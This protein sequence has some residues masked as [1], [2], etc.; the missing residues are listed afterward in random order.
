M[1]IK[2]ALNLTLIS[3]LILSIPSPTCAR[4]C[5]KGK[6]CGKGCIAL[7]K[8][9]RID[10]NPSSNDNTFRYNPGLQPGTIIHRTRHRLPRVHRITAKSITAVDAP[11]S[12]KTNRKYREGQRVFVYET[13]D[14]WARISNM[15]PEEWLELKYL[16]LIGE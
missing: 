12:N 8:T 2:H 1:D 14:N 6:S 13:Y 10:S 16:K 3:S 4:N 7:D 5:I 11:N 15:Q 9:C